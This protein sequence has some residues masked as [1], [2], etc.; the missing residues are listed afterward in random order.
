MS[1]ET[2]TTKAYKVSA[3]VKEKLEA[4]FTQSGMDTQESFIEH[5]ALQY[6]MQQLK[7]GTTGYKKQLDELDYHT[8]RVGELFLGMIQTEG[9]E[10]LELVQ[11]YDEKLTERAS[12]IFSQE[13]QISEA[14]KLVK[15]RDEDLAKAQ[16]ENADLTIQLGQAQEISRKDNLLVDEYNKRIIS[17]SGMLDENKAAVD[18]NKDLKTKLTELSK[19]TIEQ[20]EK[21]QKLE[22][23]LQELD[24]SRLDQLLQQGK[25]NTEDMQRLTDRKDLEK[26]RELLAVRQEY[27]AKI[28]KSNAADTEKLR[29]L[30]EEL[31]KMREASNKVVKPKSPGENK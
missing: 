28:E 11:G 9:A 13:Q 3:E 2:K 24:G 29:G 26:E 1:N 14:S 25:R 15:Q 17:L 7:E 18:E 30:Y 31:N 6:E 22:S 21:I 23:D 20:T 5:I 4:L 10:R 27:Q 19:L 12:V 16:K 8:K